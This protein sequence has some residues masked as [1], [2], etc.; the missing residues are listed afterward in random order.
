MLQKATCRLLMVCEVSYIAST[1]SCENGLQWDVACVLLREMPMRALRRD[2]LAEIQGLRL[3]ESCVQ[4]AFR[5]GF[6]EVFKDFE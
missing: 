5:E 4:W 6:L 3:R 1:S 2:L